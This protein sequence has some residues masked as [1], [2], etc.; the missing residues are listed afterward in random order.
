MSN[1]ELQLQIDDLTRRIET[2]EKAQNLDQNALLS[3]ILNGLKVSSIGSYDSSLVRTVTISSTPSYFD[4]PENP[5]GTAT[6]NISGTNYRI[7]L[8]SMT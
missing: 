7:L 1:E 3:N 6:V 4:I 2:M 5:I 8:Y